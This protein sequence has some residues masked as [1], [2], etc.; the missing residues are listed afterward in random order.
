[1]LLLRSIQTV[2]C[3][4]LPSCDVPVDV[5]SYSSLVVFQARNKKSN[6]QKY[7][8]KKKCDILLHFLTSK[9]HETRAMMLL[10]QSTANINAAVLTT[11]ACGWL[12]EE[13]S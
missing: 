6:T 1:M 7:F 8:K 12:E 13:T 9:Q 2:L 11:T 10:D 3:R 5:C 4:Q